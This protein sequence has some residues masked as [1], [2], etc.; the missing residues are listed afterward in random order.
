[1]VFDVVRTSGLVEIAGDCLN[2][3]YIIKYLYFNLCFS[4]AFYRIAESR[5]GQ[6]RQGICIAGYA[7]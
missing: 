7:S 6:L 5:A 4:K 2:T 3:I 1:M